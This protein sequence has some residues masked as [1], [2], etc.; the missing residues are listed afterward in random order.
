MTDSQIENLIWQLSEL[1]KCGRI[2]PA[3]SLCHAIL[4]ESPRE[5]RAWKWLATLALNQRKLDDAESAFRKAISLELE[6]GRN[7]SGLGAAL[8]GKS[9]HTEA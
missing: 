8:V 9:N 5:L 7:W 3:E 2:E 6:N 4:Q 1:V